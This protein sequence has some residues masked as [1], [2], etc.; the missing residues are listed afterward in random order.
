MKGMRYC[1]GRLPRPNC[2]CCDGNCGTE[3]GCAC[4]ACM[5]LELDLRKL[6]RQ[7]LINRE[8]C[9]PLSSLLSLPSLY[10][11]SS[12]SLPLL[13]SFSSSRL[14]SFLFSTLLSLSSLLFSLPILDFYVRFSR[15]YHFLDFRFLF[16][17]TFF[18]FSYY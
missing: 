16:L 1:G 8:V 10:P 6:P 17:S 12:C 4:V 9:F 18:S 5:A 2:G 14:L 11:F 15:F 3:S 13:Y 7:W